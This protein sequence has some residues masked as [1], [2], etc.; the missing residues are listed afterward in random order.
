MPLT[1]RPQ[2]QRTAA[3]QQTKRITALRKNEKVQNTHNNLTDNID[4]YPDIWSVE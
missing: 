4:Q 3:Q 1:P 2:T